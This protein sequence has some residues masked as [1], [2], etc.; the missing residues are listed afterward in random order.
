MKGKHVSSKRS[1]SRRRCDSYDSDTSGMSD[2]SRSRST[3]RRRR[4]AGK[5]G[6]N[7]TIDDSGTSRVKLDWPQHRVHFPGYG[8][9]GGV[10][11]DQLSLPMFVHGFL[12][13]VLYSERVSVDA[14]HKLVHLVDLMFDAVYYNWELVREVHASLLYG[15]EYGSLTWRSRGTFDA[16]R[17]R[18]YRTQAGVARGNASSSR[19]G[20]VKEARVA[21]SRPRYC[22]GFQSGNCSLQ[23][24]HW[25][26][27]W[28]APMLH[29]CSACLVVRGIQE[30]HSSQDCQYNPRPFGGSTDRTNHNS[31]EPAHL[32]QGL[33]PSRGLSQDDQVT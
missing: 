7:R 28:N 31:R 17:E 1:V 4:R 16:I 2:D 15:I 33:G 6:R 32:S 13:N 5:S 18:H 9:E 22:G 26:P 10:T 3:K 21:G 20:P 19:A 14:E 29:V 11:Y 12:K 25:S 24:G 27:R 23:P 30:P 8:K